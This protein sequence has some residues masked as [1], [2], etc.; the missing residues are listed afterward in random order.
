MRGRLVNARLVEQ[1]ER[2]AHVP[3]DRTRNRNENG[4]EQ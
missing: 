3:L 1:V 2:G 4:L